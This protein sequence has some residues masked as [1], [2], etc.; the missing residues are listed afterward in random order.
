MLSSHHNV[1]CTTVLRT[2]LNHHV[3]VTFLKLYPN[4]G[5]GVS[6]LGK[7]KLGVKY[8]VESGIRGYKIVV[9]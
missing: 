4:Y 6:G 8:N 2:E 7:W 3:F 1:E 9:S 5:R